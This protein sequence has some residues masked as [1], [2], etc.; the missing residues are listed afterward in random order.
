MFEQ[1]Y[2]NIKNIRIVIIYIIIVIGLYWKGWIVE[3]RLKIF[4]IIIISILLYR[5]W[6]YIVGSSVKWFLERREERIWERKVINK[7]FLWGRDIRYYFKVLL[8]IYYIQNIIVYWIYETDVKIYYL[9]R[10]INKKYN[11]TKRIN[12]ILIL[13]IISVVYK[14]IQMIIGMYFKIK[15]KISSENLFLIF[16]R[17]LYGL[18]I[19]TI[20]ITILF[21]YVT[22]L[23]C[24]FRIIYVYIILIIL[25][26]LFI[27]AKRS[28][29]YLE[30]FKG[31]SLFSISHK[32]DMVFL[33]EV[34]LESSVVGRIIKEMRNSLY[35]NK[36][37]VDF[38]R[39]YIWI[40][41][42]GMK[43]TESILEDKKWFADFKLK[44]R[45]G[46][47]IYGIKYV[48]NEI[49]DKIPFY[50]LDLYYDEIGWQSKDIFEIYYIYL[51]KYINL[52][53]EEKEIISYI[54][55]IRDEELRYYLYKIWE[56]ERKIE[57]YLDDIKINIE[58]SKQLGSFKLRN[59]IDYYNS[60]NINLNG[61]GSDMI[62]I[63]ENYEFYLKL[64]EEKI[65]KFNWLLNDLFIVKEKKDG[66]HA[67]LDKYRWGSMW[68][69]KID[70]SELFEIFREVHKFIEKEREKWEELDKKGEI[71]FFSKKE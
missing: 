21:D 58:I 30:E 54:K 65:Y 64:M 9:V 22:A 3:E 55:E 2:L 40:L 24:Y 29:N 18:I 31:Y 7:N 10:K 12:V 14:P 57:L 8:K 61:M 52:T 46:R 53:K 27:F 35:L 41:K 20:M 17:R 13:G 67:I 47:R 49:K 32:I 28:K 38:D 48:K 4:I 51:F 16:F 69:E 39:N 68:Y 26:I 11:K 59:Q 71:N 56:L 60:N 45:L 5:I 23:V 43:L 63:E 50:F 19:S 62:D 37:K 15:N 66:Y 70:K 33:I 1:R 25:S 42:S 36:V 44:V 6:L 34:E